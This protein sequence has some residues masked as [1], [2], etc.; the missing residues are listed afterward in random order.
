MTFNAIASKLQDELADII[1]SEKEVNDYELIVYK[2]VFISELNVPLFEEL[3]VE[4]NED[5]F[6]LHI[7]P[8]DLEFD[9]LRDLDDAFDKFTITF[10]PNSYNLLKL[11]FKLSD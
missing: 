3:E 1:K 5:S 2:Y 10:L 4:I 7:I 8:D 9:L 11:N 6:V